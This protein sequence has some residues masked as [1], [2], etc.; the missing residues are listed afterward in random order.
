MRKIKEKMQFKLL[1][2]I[3]KSLV[4]LVLIF[5]APC[6]AASLITTFSFDFINIY[7]ILFLFEIIIVGFR[8][9]ISRYRIKEIYDNIE[10]NSTLKKEIND[11]SNMKNNSFSPLFFLAYNFEIFFKFE[12]FLNQKF[13]SF[14]EKVR[15]FDEKIQKIKYNRK[16]KETILNYNL[17]NTEKEISY[18]KNNNNKLN[19]F[20]RGI[21]KIKKTLVCKT[22]DSDLCY[23]ELLRN[24]HKYMKIDDV[25]IIKKSNNDYELIK[26]LKKEF[27]LTDNI[28]DSLEDIDKGDRNVIYNELI[29]EKLGFEMILNI[30]DFKE[31]NYCLILMNNGLKNFYNYSLFEK[32][33]EIASAVFFYILDNI[34]YSNRIKKNDEKYKSIITHLENDLKDNQKSLEIQLEQISYMYEEIVILYESGKNLG[35]IFD[36]KKI[37]EMILEMILDIVEADY[38]MVYYYLSEKKDIN[39]STIINQKNN[40]TDFKNIKNFVRNIE[41]YTA[42]KENITKIVVNNANQIDI[43]TEEKYFKDKN[44]KNFI[45][46][47]IYSG[48]EIVGAVMVINKCEGEFTA[49]NISLATALTNQ[50]GLYVQNIDFLD[51]EIDR[52]KEE[53]QLKIANK[54]QSK[55]FPQELV[56]INHYETYGI[57]VPAK[58]VGGDYFDF[59][60]LDENNLIGIIADVSGKGIPAALLVSMVRTIF[61]MIVEHFNERDVDKILYLMNNILCK[62]NIEG[63]FVTAVCYNL[64]GNTNTL[65]IANAGH[66]PSL[67]YSNEKNNI[68]EVDTEGMV[69][70]IVQNEFFEKKILNIEK[71]DIFL[72]YT[73]GV[74]EARS[75]TGEFFELNKLKR[76]LLNNNKFPSGYI[77]KK[78][79]KDVNQFMKNKNQDDDITVVSIKGV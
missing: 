27:H 19:E 10:K 29:N 71:G 3:I 48:S 42:V 22:I 7:L 20:L 12:N 8:H 39:F 36:R 47:P 33:M 30:T 49:A 35:K 21:L 79:Y 31:K 54:I 24:I 57:N 25:I 4:I 40:E 17:E 70:G 61:R 58:A 53:E 16:M 44:I 68:K 1:G 28:K 34:N 23:E 32:T 69:L 78:I 11:K 51:K 55:L 65:E 63:R 6:I 14:E 50:M 15:K 76:I 64:N 45:K 77:V 43:D 75:N 13:H 18:I 38:S 62:E 52:K 46:V 37:E 56:S 2:G 67:F 59:I 60:K 41:S 26:F 5:I 74:V 72:L 73:D 9:V 66:N